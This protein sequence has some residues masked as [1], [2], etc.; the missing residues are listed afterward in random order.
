M[1]A[2]PTRFTLAKRTFAMKATRVF[3]GA[4][5]NRPHAAIIAA[6]RA[7][8]SRPRSLLPS[9]KA[10]TEWSPQACQRFFEISFAP[11]RGHVQSP[12]PPTTL[13]ARPVAI[14]PMVHRLARVLQAARAP[15]EGAARHSPSDV[16][17]PARRLLVRASLPRFSAA[18]K[19]RRAKGE[20]RRLTNGPGLMA[21]SASSRAARVVV[22]PRSGWRTRRNLAA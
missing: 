16:G 14:G 11:Q 6:N 22:Q 5:S 10:S 2:S 15:R 18:A 20:R 17:L 19:R 13:P 8:S 4:T 9:R 12:V 3:A 1:C 21:V 7:K